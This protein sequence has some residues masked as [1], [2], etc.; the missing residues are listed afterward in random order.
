MRGRAFMGLLALAGAVGCG[1]IAP[2]HDRDPD[3]QSQTDPQ[4]TTSQPQDAGVTHDVLVE[5]E[6]GDVRDAAPPFCG[7]NAGALFCDDF[8]DGGVGD[9]WSGTDVVPGGNLALDVDVDASPSRALHASVGLKATLPHAF[10][11]K[12]L[13]DGPRNVTCS[14]D[15]FR[16]TQGDDI[17]A[18]LVYAF[19][20][21]NGNRYWRL[22]FTLQ[23]GKLSIDEFRD[24]YTTHLPKTSDGTVPNRQSVHFDVSVVFTP[25]PRLE[26]RVDDKVVV[27]TSSID[28]NLDAGTLRSTIGLGFTGGPM[29]AW[30][31]RYDNF[32]C[33]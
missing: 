24:T 5:A 10:L 26:V 20:L 12:D 4:D 31:M 23:A 28:P 16:D 8:D 33:R 17:S 13:A 7:T 32:I 11:F 1:W 21:K 6:A 14:F 30:S 9:E 27:G 22:A 29:A 19:E 15:V 3:G 2:L 18:A 25:A